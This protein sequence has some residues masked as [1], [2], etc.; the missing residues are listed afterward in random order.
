MKKL[1]MHSLKKLSPYKKQLNN[2]EEVKFD[3]YLKIREIKQ[4][5]LY[6]ESIL[7][8]DSNKR[9]KFVIDNKEMLEDLLDNLFD[10][11][12]TI[13]DGASLDKEAMNLTISLIQTVRNTVT[14]I[15]NLYHFKG[16]Q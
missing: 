1:S 2:I 6:L 13:V 5:S 12:I 14:V 16:N 4:I 10:E 3:L 11:S 7:S 9:E 15:Q 8:L